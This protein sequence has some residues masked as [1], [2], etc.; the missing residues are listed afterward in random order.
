L[1]FIY[2]P[3]PP[4]AILYYALSTARLYLAVVPTY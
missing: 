1:R 4:I 3:I 2:A